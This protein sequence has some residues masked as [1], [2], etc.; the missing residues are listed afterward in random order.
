MSEPHDG[1]WYYVRDRQKVGPVDLVQLQHLALTGSLQTT[2]MVLQDGAKHW[3]TAGTIPGL[4]GAPAVPP[5]LPATPTTPGVKPVPESVEHAAVKPTLAAS[6]DSE[7]RPS[8]QATPP[9]LPSLGSVK[10]ALRPLVGLLTPRTL[11][12]I[13]AGVATVLAVVVSVVLAV[14]TGGGDK[15]EDQRE[16]QQAGS[17]HKEMQQEPARVKQQDNTVGQP[18]ERVERPTKPADTVPNPTKPPSVT[19]EDAKILDELFKAAKAAN[20]TQF[21][22]DM[23]DAEKSAVRSY[24]EMT[25]L[26]PR[27]GKGV[28]DYFIN[29][30]LKGGYSFSALSTGMWGHFHFLG[31]G[32]KVK[33]IINDHEIIAQDALGVCPGFCIDGISTENLVDDETLGIEHLV[34]VIAGTKTYK[35]P[36]GKWTVRRFVTLSVKRIKALVT[37]ERTGKEYPESIAQIME[38]TKK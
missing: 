21:L 4:F 30:E 27:T 34:F 26:S 7:T 32:V 38:M 11:P 18:T 37:D 5:G 9:P 3:V 15:K 1:R 23:S 25:F 17:H 12:W 29:N 19:D 22:K 35:T 6:S 20:V 2:D 8:P 28:P 13:V 24:V 36:T 33:Q 16:Q 10:P 14:R 31:I